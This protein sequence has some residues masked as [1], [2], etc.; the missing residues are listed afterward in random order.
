MLKLYK[1]SSANLGARAVEDGALLVTTDNGG[2]YVDDG[3]SRVQ[4]SGQS[5]WNQNDETAIGY[6]KN[7]TH[8]STPSGVKQLDEIYIP[9]T[10]ARTADIPSLN[11]YA[12]Q[13]ELNTVAETVAAHTTQLN[14]YETETWTFTLTDGSVVTKSIV[15]V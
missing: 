8:Y 1:G 6:V 13:A 11:G 14:S 7:R 5:D 10:I 15:V 2:I 3:G 9:N 12:T 4:L